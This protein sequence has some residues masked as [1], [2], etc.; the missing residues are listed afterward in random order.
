MAVAFA[1]EEEPIAIVKQSQDVHPEGYEFS[2]ETANGIKAEESGALKNA[3]G[4]EESIA[5][6]G[7]FEYTAPDGTPVRMTYI[8]DENGYQPSGDLLPV[9]PEIP[10]HVVRALEYIRTHPPKD[11]PQN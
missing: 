11:E 9:A 4:E 1:A 7:T 2:Y 5:V 3:G 10:D 8:A 6:Q